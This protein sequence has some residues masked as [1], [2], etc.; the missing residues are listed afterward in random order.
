MWK[1]EKLTT[2]HIKIQILQNIANGL[3]NTENATVALMGSCVIS[4][5]HT[6]RPRLTGQGS[7][8]SAL[9]RLQQAHDAHLWAKL[10]AL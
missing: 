10:S 3:E 1:R 2:L 8:G 5:G 9:V 7:D 6:L 4:G